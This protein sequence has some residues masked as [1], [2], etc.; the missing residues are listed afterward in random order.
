MFN[1]TFQYNSRY[2]TYSVRLV[3]GFYGNGNK[4]VQFMDANDGS[5]VLIATTNLGVRNPEDLITIKNYSEN[6]GV[7]D[8]LMEIGFVDSIDHYEQAGFVKVPVCHLS[9][10][11]QK[12]FE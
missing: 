5:P 1:Q 12:F 11:G 10:E 3:K 7:L 9:A 6:E 2:A 8:F 4:A